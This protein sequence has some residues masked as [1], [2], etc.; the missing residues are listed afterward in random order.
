LVEA[1]EAHEILE[2][3]Q[4]I[5]VVGLSRHAEKTAHAVP[6]ALQAAGFRIV[7]VNPHADEILGEKAYAR[8]DEVPDA[9]DV[10][11]V[12]RPS[13]EAPDIA[14]QAVAIGA[15][16]LW[17]QQGLRSDEARS[18]AEG[19]GLAYVENRCMAVEQELHDIRRRPGPAR[20]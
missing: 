20:P 2:R 1:M 16:A 3:S 13:A 17:L 8:L 9:V 14:R 6:A 5:A 11:E 7:P 18:I 19:A 12:F 15:K 10:V 4:T